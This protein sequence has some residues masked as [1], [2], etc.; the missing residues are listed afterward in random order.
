MQKCDKN[1]LS[2]SL[3]TNLI[4]HYCIK[5]LKSCYVACIIKTYATINIKKFIL[6]SRQQISYRYICISIYIA[7]PY[8]RA[9]KPE[10]PQGSITTRPSKVLLVL[11]MNYIRMQ[12]LYTTKLYLTFIIAMAVSLKALF[13]LPFSFVLQ[14]RAHAI[15]EQVHF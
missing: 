15:I 6:V 2:V 1:I 9:P 11:I 4:H 3:T 14:L 5:I 13:Q 12:T 7:Y 10:G 8:Y